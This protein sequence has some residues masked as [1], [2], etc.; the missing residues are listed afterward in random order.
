VSA[1]QAAFYRFYPL[2]AAG[3]I[4]DRHEGYF[5]DDAAAIASA[6]HVTHNFPAL[7]IWCGPRKVITPS[8]GELARLQQPVSP[9]IERPVSPVDQ[10]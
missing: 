9:P 1:Q 4:A 7:E 2:R 10:P 5:A 6:K 8:R 3:R